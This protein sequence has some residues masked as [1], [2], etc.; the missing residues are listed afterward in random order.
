MSRSPCDPVPEED[1]K[2]LNAWPEGTIGHGEE[3]HLIRHLNRVCQKFGYGRVNQL[4]SS[5]RDIWYNPENVQ[6]YQTERDQRLNQL[7][8][9]EDELARLQAD[10]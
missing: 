7:K 1:L 10:G 3:Q 5:I 2:C 6:K 8:Q 9:S 4:V